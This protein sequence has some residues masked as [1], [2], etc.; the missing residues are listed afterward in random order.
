MFD[1]AR[2]D[3]QVLK[4]SVPVLVDFTAAWCPPCRAMEPHVEAMAQ[5]WAVRCVVGQLDV[6]QSPLTVERYGVRG[7]PTF[8]VFKNGM[9]LLEERP[10]EDVA[11]LLGVSRK[12]VA[13]MLLRAKTH[14][15]ACT[16]DH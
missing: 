15:R 12:H 3:A 7:M 11:D 16:L 14:L 8:L 1:D 13:V 4:R 2:F 6:E 5:R 10:G 9:R